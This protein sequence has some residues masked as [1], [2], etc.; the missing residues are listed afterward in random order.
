MRILVTG[1]AG[2]IGAH[3]VNRLAASTGAGDI[4]VLDNLHRGHSLDSLPKSVEFRKGDIRDR[5]AVADAVRERDIVFHLA[6]QSNVMGAAA[7]PEYAF[8]T[9]VVG[10]NTVLEAA[11]AAGVK[12]LVFTSSR[13]VY[14]DPKSTPVLETAAMRAKN[15]YGAS[16]VAGEV[17]CRLASQRGLETA[18][19]RLANVYGSGDRDRVI[20]LFA[21]AA[22]AGKP[23]TI[24]GSGK[25]LDFVWIDTVVDAL[26][27]AGCG[28]Y[29]R[30]PLNVGSGKGTTL[31]D[32]ARRI[33]GLTKSSSSIEVT[34]E[35]DQE[36]GRFVADITR[37]RRLLGIQAPEDPLWAL[38]KM[39]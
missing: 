6:A 33:V 17:Y 11:A 28:R 4:L 8:S 16:K 21:T 5:D 13:E 7:D 18:V 25:T 2:F 29:I 27:Q 9:N 23:I 12:R 14:G 19:L 10:T 32:L 38:P 30:G 39:M 22:R 3:L 35:R 1:G 36:V 20:P 26:I 24:F 34:E 31:L 15:A 37:A